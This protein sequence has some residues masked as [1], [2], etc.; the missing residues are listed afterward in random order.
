MCNSID[1]WHPLILMLALEMDVPRCP[2]QNEGQQL[3]NIVSKAMQKKNCPGNGHLVSMPRGSHQRI[4]GWCET[5]AVKS[6]VLTYRCWIPPRWLC[7]K[8]FLAA[9]DSLARSVTTPAT[10]AVAWFCQLKPCSSVGPT[11]DCHWTKLLLISSCFCCLLWTASIFI[12][13]L[14]VNGICAAPSRLLWQ[15]EECRTEE[16]T[17]CLCAACCYVQHFFDKATRNGEMV[18][19]ATPIVARV[20]LHSGRSG[21]FECC[22]DIPWSFRLTLHRAFHCAPGPWK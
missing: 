10:H 20:W 15:R 14:F 22:G 8:E 1:H 6:V 4:K 7:S 3:G 12:S 11:Q 13:K 16:N 17:A 5:S 18:E 19:L 2:H 9:I 21:L